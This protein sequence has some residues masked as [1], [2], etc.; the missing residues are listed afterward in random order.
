MKR[1]LKRAIRLSDF[2]VISSDDLLE[3][4]ENSY[5]KIRRSATEHHLEKVAAFVCDECGFAVYAPREYKTRLPY[6]KHYAGAPI[7]CL[8]STE[9]PNTIENVNASIFNGSQES[10]LHFRLK[11]TIKDLLINDPLTS[12]NT[13][14]VEKSIIADGKLRRPDVQVNYNGRNLV[15]EIQL[16]STQLP[17]IVGREKF[18]Q[19]N[20]HSLIWVTWNFNPEAR[21]QQLSSISDILYSHNNNL[22]SLD[23]EVIHESI[24]KRV[25]MLRSFWKH[26]TGWESKTVTL[27]ELTWPSS[28]LPFAVA[29]PSPWHLEF[30]EKWINSTNSDGTPWLLKRGLLYEIVEKINSEDITIQLL[31][32][33]DIGELLNAILSFTSGNPIGSG[34]SNLIEVINTFLSSNRRHRFAKILRGIIDKTNNSKIFER[35]SVQN[36]FYKAEHS[37]QDNRDSIAGQVVLK[38]FP[39]L[40]EKH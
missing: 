5:Q 34:Q 26:G 31:N 32:D 22:F 17:I 23:N 13:V 37:D 3:M 10:P 39:D 18:Y 1:S 28:G 9:K 21:N 36:T 11:H 35:K 12:T 24:T 16:A 25:F 6:W 7:R 2:K 19:K 15:F 27:S 33:L 30:R 29:P 38:L 4:D 40:F 8:W 14:Y 20:G